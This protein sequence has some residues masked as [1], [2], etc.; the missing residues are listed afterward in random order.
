MSFVV[1]SVARRLEGGRS[2]SPGPAPEYCGDHEIAVNRF[3]SLLERV[4]LLA[5]LRIK[6]A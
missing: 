3:K 1:D 6:P 5:I 2:G 4:S